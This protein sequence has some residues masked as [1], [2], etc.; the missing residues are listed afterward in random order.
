MMLYSKSETT[1][2]LVRL[3]LIF[4]VWCDGAGVCVVWGGV[5]DGAILIFSLLKSVQKRDFRR[6][7]RNKTNSMKISIE[8]HSTFILF[9]VRDWW[10]QS[11]ILFSLKQKN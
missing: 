7:M 8:I 9:S 10:E 6:I 4:K 5:T 11:Y 1:T 2:N 3:I